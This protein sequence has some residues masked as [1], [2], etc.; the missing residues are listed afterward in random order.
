MLVN[1]S[2]GFI[3]G[4]LLVLSLA[5]AGTANAKAFTMAG[6]WYQNRGPLVDIPINGGPVVCVP[7]GVLQTGC[8]GFFKPANG[9]IPGG[10]AVSAMG[11]NPASFV[12]PD[13]AFGQA[14]G[15]Q[16]V[17]VAII[18][19]VVQLVTSFTFDGPAN[20][21]QALAAAPSFAAG[22]PASFGSNAWSNDAGQTARLAATFAW[23]PGVGGPACAAGTLATGSA[24]LQ[25]IVSYTPGANAF[26]GTMGM[27]LAGGGAT[28]IAP[29][30]ASAAGFPFL[31]HLP[32][33]G[34]GMN[35]QHPGVGYAYSNSV[36]LGSA[37]FYLGFMTS[38]G[39]GA[40]L[41][42]TTGPPV[43]TGGT[44]M[45]PVVIAGDTNINWGM[46]WTTGTVSVMNTE[47]TL[48]N[49][50]G[51][52]TAM[53]TDSRTNAGKGRITMVAGGTSHRTTSTLDF[54]ALEVIVLDFEDGSPT[55]SMGP[56]GLATVAMLMALSA[57]YAI[58]SKFNA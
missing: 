13:N 33:M 53:G 47:V 16:V 57:G 6:S 5:V 3:T 52:I 14:L 11:A 22:Q 27:M 34:T 41:L 58:R 40:G 20:I 36:M 35:P 50:T 17:A 45:S 21:G 37:P 51:T 9:G 25:G 2:L 12:I 46:P 32:I 44:G 15:A 49:Q 39:N 43:T 48:M 4:A 29:P 24:G 31:A 19:T 10:G 55:P 28:S 26:G 42:T 54:E 1:R 30:G 7:A 23:C 18:P 38:T 56:A 8:V